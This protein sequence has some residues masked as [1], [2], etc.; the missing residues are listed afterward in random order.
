MTAIYTLTQFVRRRVFQIALSLRPTATK[1]AALPAAN[2]PPQNGAP[3][4]P[5]PPVKP[6]E[7]YIRWHI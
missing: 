6:P 5:Q 2:A 3:P 4:P 1:A 7:C